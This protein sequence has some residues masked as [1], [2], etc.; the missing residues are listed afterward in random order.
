MQNVN[1]RYLNFS[2]SILGLPLW[3]KEVIY[4]Q[5]EDDL[6]A[7]ITEDFL[8]SIENKD[9]FQ[10]ESPKLT[11]KGKKELESRDKGFSQ[12]LYKFL[13]EVLKGYKII[14][15]VINNFWTLEECAKFYVESVENELIT[16]P[17]SIRLLGTAQYLSGAIRLGEFLVR[18]EKISIDELNE[19]LNQ[20]Q[21]IIESTGD[22]IGIASVLMNKDYVSE[23]DV[24]A[25]LKIKDEAKKRFIFNFKLDSFES[26]TAS[27]DGDMIVVKEQNSK[28]LKEN[29][30]LKDQLRKILNISK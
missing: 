2:D 1:N 23:K 18:T 16:M 7:L 15:L 29:K 17:E 28:L 14:E 21:H 4:L 12:Q 19:A 24:Q 3:I 6:E 10:L 30:L 22:R 20:Q 26:S 27:N 8:E 9:I 25:I 13:G 5:L 11:Y